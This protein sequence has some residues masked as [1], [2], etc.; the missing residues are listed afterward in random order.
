MH[1]QFLPEI[2]RSLTHTSISAD[3][4]SGNAPTTRVRRRI[5]RFICSI[6]L[7]VRIFD[8]CCEYVS[9]SSIPPLLYQAARSAFTPR[10]CALI[11]SVRSTTS[12][13]SS[14]SCIIFSDMFLYSFFECF[15]V[16]A[17]FYRKCGNMSIFLPPS[18]C[19]IFYTLFIDLS[20][21]APFA[22]KYG[23]NYGVFAPCRYFLGLRRA[24]SAS[25]VAKRL[26]KC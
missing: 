1:P 24:S 22:E 17:S 15:V 9:V 5:S 7:L 20:F 11:L 4:P 21:N 6:T 3:L 23:N 10:F 2:Y 14:L 16:V 19:E 18:F 12:T 26:P 13:A 8:Q 25:N